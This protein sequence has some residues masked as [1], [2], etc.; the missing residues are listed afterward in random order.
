[1]AE[2]TPGPWAQL[3][4]FPDI[5][6]PES[7]RNLANGGSIHAYDYGTRYAR[8]IAK[9]FKGD[10]LEGNPKD[11]ARL[12]AKAWLIPELVEAL[13]HCLGLLC[14]SGNLNNYRNLSDQELGRAWVETANEARAALACA[15]E[16]P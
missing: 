9:V 13:T 6:V 1:M 10:F 11:T 3:D 8:Q 14:E 15:K 12:I 2:H 5:I 7:D 16:A 4:G